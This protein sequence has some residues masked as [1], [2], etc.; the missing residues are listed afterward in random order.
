MNNLQ[1]YLEPDTELAQECGLEEQ[2]RTRLSKKGMK[3]IKVL[4]DS[5]LNNI[6][7]S[8]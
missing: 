8:K 7:R 6:R 5:L 1:D 2:Q 4:Q 3:N